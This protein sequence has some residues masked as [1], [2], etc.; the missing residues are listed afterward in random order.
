MIERVGSLGE[1]EDILGTS[2]NTVKIV[3]WFIHM[4]VMFTGWL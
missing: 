4:A 2:V 3:G 1:V